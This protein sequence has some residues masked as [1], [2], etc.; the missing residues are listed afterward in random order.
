MTYE[1][2]NDPLLFD[3]EDVFM[4]EF[5]FFKKIKDLTELKE[6]ALFI[7]IQSLNENSQEVSLYC[8]SFKIQ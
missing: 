6:K 5:K 8:I 3:H 2:T 4:K 1:A 7:D